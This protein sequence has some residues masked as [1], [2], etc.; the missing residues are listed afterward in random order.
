MGVRKSLDKGKG[1]GLGLRLVGAQLK[2]M[3]D[4]SSTL[5][6]EKSADAWRDQVS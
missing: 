1:K 5:S 2:H 4:N 3:L 6:S